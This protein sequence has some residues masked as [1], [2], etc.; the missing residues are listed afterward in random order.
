MFNF[1]R[2]F[3]LRYY[4]P[5]V[6]KPE[7]SE[8]EQFIVDD[9]EQSKATRNL[10]KRPVL[11]YTGLILLGL[12]CTIGWLLAI[13]FFFEFHIS[14]KGGEE[15]QRTSSLPDLGKAKITV[16]Q[17][18]SGQW[19]ESTSRHISWVTGPD[20]EDGF[21]L[22]RDPL[23][24][25]G[26]RVDDLRSCSIQ[27][28]GPVCSNSYNLMKSSHILV[29]DKLT[30][31]NEALPSPDLKKILL[32][33]HKRKN[34]RHSFTGRYWI[35]DV[36]TQSTQPLDPN[37]DLTEI[38]WASWSPRSDVIAFVRSHNIYLRRLS[39]KTVTQITTDGGE[40]ML[41]GV[42]DW[43]YEEE[44]LQ[45]GGAIW[46]SED[47]RYIAYLRT[48]DSQVPEY[49]VQYYFSRPTGQKPA[50]GEENYPDNR[51]YKY[52]KAGA[53]IPTVNLQ[54]LNVDN[55]SIMSVEAADPNRERV[56]LEV[57][58]ASNYKILMKETNR[59]F[60]IVQTIIIDLENRSCETVRVDDMLSLDG[61]WV[62]VQPAQSMVFVPADPNNNR[63]YN[64]YVDIVVHN[65]FK[66]LGYFTPLTNPNPVFLTSGQWEVVNTPTF[67]PNANMVYFV[68]NREALTQRHVY[69]VRLHG[70]SDLIS[71]SDTSEPAFV[72]P[73][74]SPKAGYVLLSY[75]GPSIPWQKIM[76]TPDNMD[77]SQYTEVIETNEQLKEM[78]KTHALPEL[79]FETITI[80]GFTLQT[81]ERRPPGFN[82][83]QKYP[84][85]F[86]PYGASDSQCVDRQF[87]VDFNS[88]FASL[89]YIVVTVDGRGT[90]F[91]G[92]KMKTMIRENLGY[93]ESH[94]QI[95][96]G[97]L[98]SR[99]PYVDETRMAIWGWSY[100][101]FLALK[102][103]EHDAG[104]TFQYGM[105]IAPVT[106]WRYYDI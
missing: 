29:D 17:I 58:W 38:Q 74:F 50:L 35:F 92:R 3:N 31:I 78:V 10:R 94:D 7:E 36:A 37:D 91:S 61:G 30:E 82:P 60:E 12:L 56:I 45:M 34:W 22:R 75:T 13:V 53:P 33:T 1:R 47:G 43:V 68:A 63:P 71:I 73:S 69:G 100:G 15:P 96:A 8:T 101:G 76:A 95:E 6:Q 102:T 64:G 40:D 104:Q 99:K 98:W 52:P 20:G 44:I 9:S 97:K 18:L 51:R 77:G 80:E 41:Y 87:T 24:K 86:A 72:M 70:S 81:L 32:L 42:P 88:Y 5:V 66:H 16:D 49:S 93:W 85:L 54:F 83:S 67:D 39:S 25:E 19:T 4:L 28:D 106:D 26:L 90:G 23:G 103:L 14:S 46:W 55:N 62:E 27:N 48:N 65:G 84:V 21:L 57:I 89:G 105:A 11:H 2:K 79:L 59:E